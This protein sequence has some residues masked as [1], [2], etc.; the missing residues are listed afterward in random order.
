MSI[1]TFVCRVGGGSSN[2][3]VFRESQILP[4]SMLA[5]ASSCEATAFA[6]GAMI[7]DHVQI[8]LAGSVATD[9]N[10]ISEVSAALRSEL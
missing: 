5:L 4:S 8:C 10:Y 3:I 7:K 1:G 6:P 9:L 2:V